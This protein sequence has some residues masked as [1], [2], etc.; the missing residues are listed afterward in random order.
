[1]TRSAFVPTR[2]TSNSVVFGPR[3]ERPEE[4]GTAAGV[5]S[6]T[7]MREKGLGGPGSSQ[8]KVSEAAAGELAINA[9]ILCL[10]E[11]AQS[12]TAI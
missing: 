5:P 9:A 7:P 3:A 4:V 2:T 1:M 12:T 11:F 8:G 6:K 10:T